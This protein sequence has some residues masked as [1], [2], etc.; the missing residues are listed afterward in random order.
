MAGV[1]SDKLMQKLCENP[2]FLSAST[3]TAGVKDA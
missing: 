2:D 1:K 3:A